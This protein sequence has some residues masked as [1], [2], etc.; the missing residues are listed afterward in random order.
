MPVATL[1]SSAGTGEQD[2]EIQFNDRVLV[3]ATLSNPNVTARAEASYIRLYKGT[4]K[5]GIIYLALKSGWSLS[6]HDLEWTGRINLKG[7]WLIVGTINH[8]SSTTHRLS[9]I[10]EQKEAMPRGMWDWE[11]AWKG[12]V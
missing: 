3:A 12:G 11:K 10:F 9:V 2:V 5:A 7:D 4:K 1:E 8:A 6:N